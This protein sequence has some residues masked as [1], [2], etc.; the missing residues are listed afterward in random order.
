[1]SVVIPKKLTPG[2]ISAS[3][4][5]IRKRYDEYI[6]KYFRPRS[7]RHA[8]EKRYVAALKAKVDVSSFLLAE[9]SAVEE[10][11]DREEKRIER[12]PVR[13]T[14]EKE[15]SFADRVLE[16]NRAR[17]NNHRDLKFHPDAGEEVRRLAGA[18]TDFEQKT[19]VD[20]GIALQE[21]MYAPNSSEMLA[22]DSQLRSLA[23]SSRDEVPSGLT[24]LVT[25]LGKFPR[26]YPT[27]DREEKAYILE[28]AFF[29]NDLLS[30]LGRVDRVY[31]DMP[32]EQKKV[33]ENATSRVAALIS[34]F[35]LK[36]LKRQRRGS[37]PEG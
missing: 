24:R 2:E 26:N 25:E 20:I 3:V 14:E 21:T 29:L 8:F 31:T 23:S 10:L 1:M 33:L 16:E 27:I 6:T 13:T 35:R 28:A 22:L 36:D 12:G 5:K 34:D 37:R 18:L 9:I 7:L 19:W 4:E 30:I 11:I 17:I 15:E 32:E